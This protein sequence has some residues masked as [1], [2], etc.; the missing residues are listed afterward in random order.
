MEVKAGYKQTEV[1]VI[2]EDWLNPQLQ[3]ITEDNAP[4]CYGIVK[5]GAFTPN[6]VPVLVIRD[7]NQDYTSDIYRSSH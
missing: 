2:P 4:I 5:L 7:L 1:G 6:G 3:E